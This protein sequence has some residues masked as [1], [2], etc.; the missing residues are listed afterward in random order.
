[1][2]IVHG[3]NIDM[4][5]EIHGKGETLVFIPGWGT[6]ITTVSAQIADFAKKFQVIA[7]DKRGTGRT[8]KTDEPYSIEQMADDTIALLDALGIHRAHI[9]G[10]SMGSMIAQVIAARYPDRVN[11]LV[12]HLGFTRIPFAIKGMMTLMRYL[13]GSKK[14]VDEGSGWIFGQKY[15]PTPESFRRQGE[16]VAQ[17]DGRKVIG[18]IRAPTL[19]VNGSKDQFVPL[20]IAHELAEGIQGSKLV[21]FDGDHT[22]ARTQPELLLTQVAGFLAG[23][24]TTNSD[25]FI[26]KS[27]G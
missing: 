9:L 2:P 14:K 6:E 23:V 17:F 20:K 15:P 21:L 13:P 24:D 3:N 10:I 27:N 4:Y 16:A 8:D 26:Q 25:N 7:I 19:I 22:I 18:M 11:G 12:L 1:M 5:Y